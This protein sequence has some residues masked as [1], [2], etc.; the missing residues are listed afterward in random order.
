MSGPDVTPLR[1]A[2]VQQSVAAELDRIAPALDPFTASPVQLKW[3]N[4]LYVDGRKLGGILIEARW[5]AGD[6]RGVVVKDAGLR[7]KLRPRLV[8]EL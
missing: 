1:M 2:D 3:P 6:N 8:V 5:R 7:F 4:D